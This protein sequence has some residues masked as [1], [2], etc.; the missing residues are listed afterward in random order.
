MNLK[1]PNKAA[2]HGFRFAPPVRPHDVLQDDDF[3][4][5]L[6]R[7]AAPFSIGIIN[8]DLSDID[9]SKVL[10]PV[11]GKDF[12]DCGTNNKLCE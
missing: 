1:T 5:E 12:I 4:G 11:R 8:L 7:L 2:A 10:Y 9:S 3:L 6:E